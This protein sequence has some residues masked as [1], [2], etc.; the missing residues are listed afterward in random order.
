MQM[1]GVA[2]EF[3][4]NANVDEALGR[5]GSVDNKVVQPPNKRKPASMTTTDPAAISSG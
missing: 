4:L 3:G 5:N 2:V 1:G